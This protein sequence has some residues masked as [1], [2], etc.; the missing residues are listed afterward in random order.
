M[1]MNEAQASFLYLVGSVIQGLAISLVVPFA[2]RTLGVVEYGLAATS[3]SLI[4]VMVIVAAAGLP[5]AITREYF[6]P[7]GAIGARVVVGLVCA[8]SV[9]VGLVGLLV[10]WA[11]WSFA[12]AIALIATAPLGV[13]AA[14]QAFLRAELRAGWFVVLAVASSAGAQALGLLTALIWH[15]AKIYLSTFCIVAC[16]VASFALLL[17]RPKMPWGHILTVR[18]ALRIGLP[19]LPHSLAL[20]L[21]SSGPV[22]LLAATAGSSQAGRYQALT[23]LVQGPISVLGA[24]NNVWVPTVLSAGEHKEIKALARLVPRM[25]RF[26]SILSVGGG[27][28]SCLATYLLVGTEFIPAS[29]VGPARLLPLSGVGYSLY[30][31][32]STALFSVRKTWPM[33]IV[34]PIVVII[35]GLIALPFA[36]MADLLAIAAIQAFAYLLLGVGT[37]FAARQMTSLG[38]SIRKVMISIILSVALVG[39]VGLTRTDAL[40]RYSEAGLGIVFGIGLLRLIAHPANDSN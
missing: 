9:F 25:I 19:I 10:M 4:Q 39:L 14:V 32:A 11:G 28:L 30:L 37:T 8:L 2:T 20:L 3:F 34:T 18:T 16:V 13:I 31:A 33:A 22:L 1:K 5:L 40:W 21:L 26:G 23:L 38:W 24:L 15:S 6:G 36:R 12:V 27:L 7:S 29:L 35:C 17:V